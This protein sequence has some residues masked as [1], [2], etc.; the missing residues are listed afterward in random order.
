MQ[1]YLESI[2]LLI[3]PFTKEIFIEIQIFV[4]RYIMQAYKT[5]NQAV[6][7][8]IR[9]KRDFGAVFLLDSRF[10]EQR[11]LQHFPEWMRPSTKVV[12]DFKAVLKD[13][14]QFFGRNKA[15]SS[16]SSSIYTGGSGSAFVNAKRKRE[17]Q[18]ASSSSSGSQQQQPAAKKK[19]V[20]KARTA[21]NV[22]KYKAGNVVLALKQRLS[23]EDM[24]AF[25][26][27]LGE[28]KR[29]ADLRGL[30]EGFRALALT[31]EELRSLGDFVRAEDAVEFKQFVEEQS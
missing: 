2:F 11:F 14:E 3:R 6:G 23:R 27:C 13:A 24:A 10:R 30:K 15:S 4:S 9:S 7:R 29:S 5:V 18:K 25:K 21:D 22:L 17:E 16:S 28:Y 19:I 8:A 1:F 31:V 20:I 12:P 26:G